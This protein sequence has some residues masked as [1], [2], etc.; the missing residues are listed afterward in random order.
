M[1]TRIALA[2]LAVLGLTACTAEPAAPSATT[3]ATASATAT[4][5]PSGDVIYMRGDE[6][7]RDAVVIDADTGR[8]MRWIPWGPVSADGSLVFTAV[9]DSGRTTVRALQLGTGN[10]LNEVVLDGIY[11]WGA[12]GMR[13]DRVGLSPSASWMVLHETGDPSSFVVLDA[14]LNVRTRVQLA[15]NFQFVAIDDDGAALY[16][17][18]TATGAGN[19]VYRLRRVDLRSKTLAPE[20]V[21]DRGTTDERVT[22]YPVRTIT[23][24]DAHRIYTLYY[25][26][27][28][29]AFVRALTPTLGNSERI[30]L[31]LPPPFADGE[32]DLAWTFTPSPDRGTAYALNALIGRIAAIDLDE[33]RVARSATFLVSRAGDSPLDAIARWFFPIAE[34]KSELFASAVVSP[35]GRNLYAT[36]KYG[37]AVLVID[38]ATLTVRSRIAGQ[39][40]GQLGLSA[41]GRRL[42]AV[43]ADGRQLIRIDPVAGTVVGTLPL[44]LDFAGVIYRIA[45]R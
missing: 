8:V 1:S 9:S 15:G 20:A 2:W 3:T 26:P 38:T 42:Y 12:Q 10:A 18:E 28:G 22:G 7:L 33:M 25:V 32:A 34:A 44:T 11:D 17:L 40:L 31:P 5:A 27:G 19:G 13:G 6:R 23:S 35:D 30:G 39:Q 14:L 37:T 16:L 4:L 43:R 41:D 36:E 45:S 24:R 21:V 29:R